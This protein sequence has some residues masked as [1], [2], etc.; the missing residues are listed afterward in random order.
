LPAMSGAV[1]CTASMRASPLKPAGRADIVYAVS[2]TVK[3]LAHD[4][5]IH[6]VPR[7]LRWHGSSCSSQ[8]AC[9]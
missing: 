6:T 2:C 8:H 5:A 4:A 1:P 7:Q 3:P 9:V